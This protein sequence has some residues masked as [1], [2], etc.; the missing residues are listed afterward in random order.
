MTDW[1]EE[2]RSMWRVE[3]QVVGWECGMA[4]KADERM[5]MWVTDWVEEKRSGWSEEYRVEEGGATGRSLC[6]VS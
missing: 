1:V 3:Y 4:G 5:G 6:G 2:G